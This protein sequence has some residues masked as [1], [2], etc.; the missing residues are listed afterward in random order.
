[1][2]VES[3]CCPDQG[4]NTNIRTL[5]ADTH[6][7]RGTA[8]VFICTEHVYCLWIDYSH[9][10]REHRLRRQVASA[11]G[12]WPL[13]VEDRAADR[14]FLAVHR[15]GPSYKIL[16]SLDRDYIPSAD[17]LQAKHV[18]SIDHRLDTVKAELLGLLTPCAV[19]AWRS[20][21]KRVR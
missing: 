8:V 2:S 4:P 13:P 18:C 11:Y 3:I 6:R 17:T 7:G 5:H 1:M 21:S 16:F 10:V 15:N 20:E 14:A 12:R 9:P 19:A